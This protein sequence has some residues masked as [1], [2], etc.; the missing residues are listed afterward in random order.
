[1][2]QKKGEEGK[3]TIGRGMGGKEKKY[4][5]GI[6][7]GRRQKDKKGLRVGE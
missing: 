5:V 7:K 4:K 6:R 2:R 3:E 1:M